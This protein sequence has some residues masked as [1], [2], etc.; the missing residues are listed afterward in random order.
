MAASWRKAVEDDV[1]KD[2][3]VVKSLQTGF[4]LTLVSRVQSPQMISAKAAR[5]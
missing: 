4:R 2:L 3:F 1:N 5:P